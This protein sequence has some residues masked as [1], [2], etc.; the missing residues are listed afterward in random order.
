MLKGEEMTEGLETKTLA[1][2]EIRELVKAHD[3]DASFNERFGICE[4]AWDKLKAGD[5]T[6][7]KCGGGG[8]DRKKRI[9]S[10]LKWEYSPEGVCLAQYSACVEWELEVFD[11]DACAIE[12]GEV[13]LRC[14]YFPKKCGLG[15]KKILSGPSNVKRLLFGYSAF[16]NADFRD[17]MLPA[18][19]FRA[20][21]FKGCACFESSRFES[22]THME[23]TVFNGKADFTNAVFGGE[24]FFKRTSFN[25]VVFERTGFESTVHFDKVFFLTKGGIVEA[26]FWDVKFKGH[27]KFTVSP[28]KKIHCLMFENSWFGGEAEITGKVGFLSLKGSCIEGILKIDTKWDEEWV[29]EAG[30]LMNLY[31][32]IMG[33]EKKCSHTALY[34]YDVNLLGNIILD[35]NECKVSEALYHGNIQYESFVKT[36]QTEKIGQKIPTNLK[37]YKHPIKGKYSQEAMADQFHTMKEAYNK[38]GSYEDEDEAMVKYMRTRN[39]QRREEAPTEATPNKSDRHEVL[40]HHTIVI[41]FILYLMSYLIPILMAPIEHYTEV[42]N[43]TDSAVKA[44]AVIFIS[45][46]LHGHMDFTVLTDPAVTAYT[47][48]EFRLFIS[49]ALLLIIPLL[50]IAIAVKAVTMG[51]INFIGYIGVCMADAIGR[52]GTSPARVVFWILATPSIFGLMFTLGHESIGPSLAEDICYGGLGWGGGGYGTTCA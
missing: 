10:T 20:A 42:V 18:T 52:F 43:S 35:W 45:D 15:I 14:K 37:R 30:R 21:V 9:Y 1:T 51:S 7:L 22:A 28:E 34:I 5:V 19:D 31:M 16:D 29:V 24:T 38:L 6:K 48:A 11:P 40:I 47:Q 26:R 13:D 36:D 33:L 3:Y 25:D 50:I 39:R 12:A 49:R 17:F 41:I 23:G 46:L 44:R 32:L 4:K 27:L 8:G 2:E